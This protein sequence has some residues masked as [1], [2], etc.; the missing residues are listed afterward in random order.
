MRTEWDR[1]RR[2][3]RLGFTPGV[4]KALVRYWMQIV[5]KYIVCSVDLTPPPSQSP[6]HD[7]CSIQLLTPL[8]YTPG[9]SSGLEPISTLGVFRVI[10]TLQVTVLH[11]HTVK[12]HQSFCCKIWEGMPLYRW[13]THRQILR[14]DFCKNWWSPPSPRPG[15]LI[16]KSNNV[17]WLWYS[18]HMKQP[19]WPKLS[20]SYQK[21]ERNFFA[22]WR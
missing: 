21:F 9:V 13:S 3:C 19:L 8:R 5:N 4:D 1:Q 14:I 7:S 6:R 17:S 18:L 20:N 12:L 16:V 2:G 22:K 10:W 15:S 11:W